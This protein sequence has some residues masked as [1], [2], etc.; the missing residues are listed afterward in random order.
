VKGNVREYIAF[1]NGAIKMPKH[2]AIRKGIS[3]P[4]LNPDYA[5]E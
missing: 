5:I 1:K 3:E 2:L 4:L